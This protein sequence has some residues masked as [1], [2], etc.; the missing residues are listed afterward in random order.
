ML[1]RM[2][3]QANTRQTAKCFACPY[4]VQVGHLQIKGIDYGKFAYARQVLKISGALQGNSCG[5]AK[6]ECDSVSIWQLEAK[7]LWGL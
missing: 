7:H 6:E 2:R 1:C 4:K 3:V 5:S